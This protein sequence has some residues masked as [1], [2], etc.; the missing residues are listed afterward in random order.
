MNSSAWITFVPIIEETQLAY[1]RECGRIGI[2][3]MNFIFMLVG[4]PV[5][6]IAILITERYGIRTSMLIACFF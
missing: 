5:N 6:N 2:D 3:Y 4:I 1:H